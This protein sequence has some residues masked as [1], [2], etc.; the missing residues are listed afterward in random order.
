[1]LFKKSNRVEQ[2]LDQNNNGELP[3]ES[4]S[5]NDQEKLGG[6]VVDTKIPLFTWRSLVM[7]LF[8]SMGGFLFGYDTGQISGFLEMNN[9]LLRYGEP[10]PGTTPGTTHH[11][12]N[13]R[14]G[15]IVALVSF[16]SVRTAP[17]YISDTTQLSIGTLIGALIGAP[18]ADRIG[19]KWSI[20]G[21]CLMVCIGVTIQISSPFGKWYQVAVGRLIAGLGVGA[22]SLLVPMYQAE[23]GPRHI[24]GTLIR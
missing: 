18:I 19:R 13:V 6:D 9:F 21:W 7:G 15:L 16:N 24:R 1:M 17:Y 10:G 20:S 12:S 5:T 23:A 11:F 22:V 4:V 8:V 2:P 3:R 14:A